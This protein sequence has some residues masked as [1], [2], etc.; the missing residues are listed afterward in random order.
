[1]RVTKEFSFCAAHILS[2]YDG[3][4]SNLHG[5]NYKLKITLE[6]DIIENKTS[7]EKG[8]VMDFGT[9]KHGVSEIIEKW[10]HAFIIDNDS[11][12]QI[13]LAS[14]LEKNNLCTRFK[15]MK[16]RT[17]AENMI[18]DIVGDVVKQ[19][20]QDNI[21]NVKTIYGKLWETP[22]SCVSHKQD[23]FEN[24]RTMGG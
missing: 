2:D 23:V 18:K 14:Y 8:M 16:G 11:Y 3:K 13:Q 10:D 17:T 22:T 5:H 20:I 12:D 4:C 24:S 15:H 7:N 9:L 6:G 1:M 21:T 19:L